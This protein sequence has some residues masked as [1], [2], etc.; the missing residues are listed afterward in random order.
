MK[1]KPG[2]ILFILAILAAVTIAGCSTSSNSGTTPTAN[3]TSSVPTPTPVPAIG[4]TLNVT[5]T[6]DLAKVHWYEY[7]IT[8]SGTPVDLGAG[9]TTA[10]S[11]MTERWDFNVDFNGQNADKMTGNGSYP[12]NSYTATTMEFVNH[13]NHTQLLS[14]NIT[15]M[16]S[17]NVIYRGSITPNLRAIISLLD[18]TNSSYTGTHTVTY[19]GTE[20]IT[21]P[22]GTYNTTKY[23][24]KG[25]Y[26]ITTYTDPAVPVPIKVKAV[27][28][29]GTIYDVELMG[30]G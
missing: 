6:I 14:G 20:T 2:S 11:V 26:N 17:G 12:S 3:P 1:F 24:Y 5:S 19:E 30:W 25:D 18:L 9:V 15:T 29:T 22:T 21:V 23:L 10:G 8:P 16:K 4:S 28:T 27:S 7:K 13:T